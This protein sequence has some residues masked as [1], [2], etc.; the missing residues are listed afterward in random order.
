MVTVKALA[1]KKEIEQRNNKAADERLKQ[2][3]KP[4]DQEKIK[5]ELKEWNNEKIKEN[6][7]N[8]S[9]LIAATKYEQQWKEAIRNRLT[10]E[11]QQ[12]IN[13]QKEKKE[14]AE[15]TRYG[16]YIDSET[17][18][19]LPR[20][21]NVYNKGKNTYFQVRRMAKGKVDYHG[22]YSTREEAERASIEWQRELFGNEEEFL[23]M[24]NEKS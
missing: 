14:K 21:V 11:R 16:N 22:T 6:T 17:G 5:A 10:P 18:E 20:W 1:L 9:E 3:N 23:K 7:N 13:L 8:L 15:K 19:Y 2:F 24:E 12:K 4:I